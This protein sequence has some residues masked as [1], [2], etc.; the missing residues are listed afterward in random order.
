MKV[1]KNKSGKWISLQKSAIAGVT[2]LALFMVSVLGALTYMERQNSV[3]VPGLAQEEKISVNSETVENEKNL[4]PTADTRNVFKIV[5][6]IP[7]DVCSVFPYMIEWGTK[8]AYDANVP[9]GYE[10]L[11]KAASISSSVQ[12][13]NS[14]SATGSSGKFYTIIAEGMKKDVLDSYANV[15]LGTKSWH[16]NGSWYKVDSGTNKTENGYFEYVGANKGLYSISRTDGQSNFTLNTEAVGLGLG[17]TDLSEIV[18]YVLTGK[19]TGTIGNIINGKKITSVTAGNY[20][21]AF[22]Y[23]PGGGYGIDEIVSDEAGDYDAKTIGYLAGGSYIVKTAIADAQGKFVWIADD[24]ANDGFYTDKKGHFETFIAGNTYADSTRYKLTFDGVN[25]GYYTITAFDYTGNGNGNFSLYFKYLGTGLG[26]YSVTKLAVKQGGYL[27]SAATSNSTNSLPTYVTKAGGD[28]SAIISNVKSVTY[29]TS[30]SDTTHAWVWVPAEEAN[31]LQTKASAMLD[32]T[33][34]NVKSSVV[35]GD[36]I[37]VRNQQRQYL[38]YARDAV[39]NNEWFKLLCLYNVKDL[40][41]VD[42]HYAYD[43]TKTPLTNVTN[44]SAWLSNFDANNRIEI[45]QVTP[46]Q[47][48]LDLVN[49]ADLMYF[50]DKEGVEGIKQNWTA[51]TGDT[52][53]SSGTSLKYT[54]D[55]PSFDIVLAIY[56]RVVMQNNMALMLNGNFDDNYTNEK[57]IKKL[58]MLM[59]TFTDATCFQYFLPSLSY[60]PEYSMIMESGAN[61]GSVYVYGNGSDKHNPKAGITGGSYSYQNTWKSEYFYVWL[62]MFSGMNA[63]FTPTNDTGNVGFVRK[64]A[65]GEYE[66][67]Y[68]F[69][70]Y[71]VNAFAQSSSMYNIW[72][73]VHNKGGTVGVSVTNATVNINGERVIYVDEYDDVFN[74]DYVA[75]TSNDYLSSVKISYEDTGSII[76]NYNSIVKGSINTENV[77]SGFTV[78]GTAGGTLD[79]SK[80]MRTVVITAVDN[81]G[82]T[83]SAT[84]KVI[85]RDIFDL[86]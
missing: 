27:Y 78:D 28:Y 43:T 73:I 18:C 7:H 47:L 16:P 25:S 3:I 60:N 58:Y 81:R 26:S 57:N 42:S 10:G 36:R 76:N 86:N 85:V 19:S 53:I 12:M 74:I 63:A 38:F 59:D 82:K 17:D 39:K 44:A 13:Y 40:N 6:V 31:M 22:P 14:E 67:K 2:A 75:T 50:S 52:S 80:K 15:T 20:S 72:A 37:Y 66:S 64:N 24:N 61:A 56:N 8:E 70:W 68:I 51:L 34:K 33:Q 84:V 21:L 71:V 62:N 79:T 49:S 65:A 9:I 48:T 77:R 35:A 32:S 41:G 29:A 30:Y 23:S 55:I 1:F 4:A 11:I 54:S 5:E 69:E 45:V 83:A 46:G